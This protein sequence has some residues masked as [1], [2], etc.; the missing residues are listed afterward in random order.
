M[1]LHPLPL[2]S[3]GQEIYVLLLDLCLLPVGLLEGSMA[4]CDYLF[5]TKSLDLFFLSPEDI[6]CQFIATTTLGFS[7]L[8]SKMRRFQYIR[9]FYVYQGPLLQE[10]YYTEIQLSKYFLKRFID[11][12]LRTPTVDSS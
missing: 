2:L 12:R 3:T 9:S 5:V 1:A 10:T 6:K 8:V 11:S 7:F 4:V